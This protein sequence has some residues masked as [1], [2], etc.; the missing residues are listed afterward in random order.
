MAATRAYR[1]I[2]LWADVV[3]RGEGED[4]DAVRYRGG[5]GAVEVL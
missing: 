1:E 4:G 3:V 5:Q 2:T